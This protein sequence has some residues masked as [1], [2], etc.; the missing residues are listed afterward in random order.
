MPD[1]LEIRDPYYYNGM[2]LRK[3]LKR[4]IDDLKLQQPDYCLCVRVATLH[5][6][7]THKGRLFWVLVAREI[8]KRLALSNGHAINWQEHEALLRKNTSV[9]MTAINLVQ[10]LYTV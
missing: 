6:A 2:G 7:R 3:M 5:Q 9:V 10:E 1:V 4:I 8:T